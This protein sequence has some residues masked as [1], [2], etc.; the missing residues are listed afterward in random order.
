M[1]RRSG[2]V[3]GGILVQL[4]QPNAR[5]VDETRHYMALRARALLLA[6]PFVI[7]IFGTLGLTP[8]VRVA[9]RDAAKPSAPQFNAENQLLRPADYREWVYLTSGLGMT[10]GPAQP[11]END[12]PRFDNVF[13]TREAYAHFLRT[14]TWPEQAMLILEVRSAEKHVSINNGGRTQGEVV[15]IEAAVKDSVRFPET[16]WGFFDFEK[17]N[18]FAAAAA[19]F[20]RSASCYSC[21]KEH[22]AVDNTFVQFYPTLLDAAKQHGTYRPTPK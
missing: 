4:G 1:P 10:Y 19:A 2:L 15:A 6:A 14:G 11:R 20:P 9:T 12:N 21:H 13:V 16:G 18:D 5:S 22:G 17:T 8:N 7:A 3:A